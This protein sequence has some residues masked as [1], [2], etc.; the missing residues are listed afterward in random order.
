MQ[1]VLV[2]GATGFI[3]KVLCGRLTD[4][5]YCVRALVRS[6]RPMRPAAAEVVISGDMVETNSWDEVLD[7]VDHIV[8]AAARA[9]VMGDPVA[10][11]AQYMQTNSDVTRRLA[12]SAARAGVK[13]FV[14]LSSIKATGDETARGRQ[15]PA[16]PFLTDPYGHS[17]QLAERYLQE[18]AAGSRMSAIIIRPPLVYGPGV[19]ANFLRLL[20]SIERRR[21]LPLGG[22]RNRRSL[23]NVWNLTDILAHVLEHAA[24][25]E[26]VWSVSDG[27]DVSTPELITLIGRAMGVRPRLVSVPPVLLRVA[28]A[29]TGRSADVAR[30][31]G[32]L[33]VD[34]T[35]TLSQ[36]AWRPRVTLNEGIVRTVA[37]YQQSRCRGQV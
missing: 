30:L 37:W 11:A 24:A 21:I 23:V 25:A 15:T 34:I 13:R 10:N 5:G 18:I 16:D 26:R 9:H 20:E 29:L 35:S 3:G 36:L 28:G 14:Y 6:Q 1:R 12:Q 22:I 17:K 2:T 32:S 33:T 7:G 4:A 8:H 31:C 27:E 19:R